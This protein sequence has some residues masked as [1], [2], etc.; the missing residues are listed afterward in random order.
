MVCS[1]SLVFG[2]FMGSLRFIM[3]L[4]DSKNFDFIMYN[5]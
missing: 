1:V 3:V 4:V 5:F 2:V